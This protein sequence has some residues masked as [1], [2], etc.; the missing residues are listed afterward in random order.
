MILVQGRGG[1][2]AKIGRRCAKIEGER[3][4]HPRIRVVDVGKMLM[5]CVI[6]GPELM[7]RA[8]CDSLRIERRPASISRYY[9]IAKFGLGKLFAPMVVVCVGL[10]SGIT[11][12]VNYLSARRINADYIC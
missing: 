3:K 12:K 11:I 7:A 4:K 9:V 2:S 10:V 6:V 8:A 1:A 5:F